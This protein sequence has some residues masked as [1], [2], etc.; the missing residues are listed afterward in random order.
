MNDHCVGAQRH[1]SRC[2]LTTLLLF[3]VLS[4]C[5]S[6]PL[7]P[8]DWRGKRVGLV[9]YPINEFAAIGHLGHLELINIFTEYGIDD[10]AVSI[11]EEVLAA[12]VERCGAVASPVR[13]SMKAPTVRHGILSAPKISTAEQN[14]VDILVGI[15]WESGA[16]PLGTTPQH[17]VV[18]S[19]IYGYVR[20][21]RSQQGPQLFCRQESKANPPTYDELVA[22]KAT[23]LKQ[24]LAQQRAACLIEF[25]AEILKFCP[26][27]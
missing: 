5:A 4:G 16:G 21:L 2:V 8:V 24:I 6:Q 22:N 12:V 19:N 15:I 20:E 27:T 9:I 10:P 25:K 7:Q 17:R 14:G 26:Q 23:R 18:D 1:S 13:L 3:I 11:G